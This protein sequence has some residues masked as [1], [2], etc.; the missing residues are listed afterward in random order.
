MR[1]RISRRRRGKH[2][3]RATC[4]RKAGLPGVS[5]SLENRLAKARAGLSK[6]PVKP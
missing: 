1:Q 4:Q 2:L 5:M 3:S 6:K